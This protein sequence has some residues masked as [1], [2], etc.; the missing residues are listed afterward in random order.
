[1]NWKCKYIEEY[2]VG[3][4]IR[5][6]EI[7][8]CGAERVRC[9]VLLPYRSNKSSDKRKLETPSSLSIW[10]SKTYQNVVGFKWCDPSLTES[11]P[12]I[13]RPIWRLANAA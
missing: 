10:I 5:S 3:I 4:K 7:S 9:K 8:L 11:L 1:M 12:A 6:R 2:L 13:C